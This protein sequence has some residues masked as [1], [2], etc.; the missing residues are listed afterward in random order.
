MFC[1]YILNHK[2]YQIYAQNNMYNYIF[3]KTIEKKLK[4]IWF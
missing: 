1:S 2:I 3:Q 4:K